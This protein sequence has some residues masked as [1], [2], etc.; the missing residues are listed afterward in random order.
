MVIQYS[1]PDYA[2]ETHFNFD[3]LHAGPRLGR[4][5]FVAIVALAALQNAFA[6][7]S[8]FGASQ[9]TYVAKKSKINRLSTQKTIKKKLAALALSKKTPVS[10]V[11]PSSS[12]TPGTTT[13][14]ASATASAITSPLGSSA[15]LTAWASVADFQPDFKPGGPAAGWTYAWNPTGKLGNSQAFAPLAWSNAAQAYNTTGAA[16]TWP[17]GNLRITMTI[18]CCMAAAVIRVKPNYLPIVGYTIQADDGAGLYRLSNSSI[19]KSDRF[20]SNNEDGL[21]VLVYLNNTLFR[22]RRTS[23]PTD[24]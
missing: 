12:S 15:A 2:N 24:W 20:S 11:A 10:A 3:T 7:D 17:T 5:L 21:G 23:A 8:S 22:H 6:L 1:Q 14:P 13:A 9:V 18:S 4:R 16:T 19:A